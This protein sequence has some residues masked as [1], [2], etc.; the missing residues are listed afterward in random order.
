MQ[1]SGASGCCS[2]LVQGSL[3]QWLEIA[4]DAK[5]LAPGWPSAPHIDPLHKP[6][7]GGGAPSVGFQR[8]SQHHRKHRED[9]PPSKSAAGN[10]GAAWAHFLRGALAKLLRSA[11]SK[12]DPPAT[13][14]MWVTHGCC[15]KVL[16]GVFRC[17]WMAANMAPS[18]NFYAVPFVLER[19][20]ARCIFLARCV[21]GTL[22]A[23]RGEA[24][25]HLDSGYGLLKDP[26]GLKLNL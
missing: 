25:V 26:G 20:L 18:N 13:L 16:G 8:R 9:P 23:S 14:S 4:V 17:L 2:E 22:S 19:P 5:T 11:G 21:L 7:P 10:V 1:N 12:S 24:N 15:A 3:L 6:G